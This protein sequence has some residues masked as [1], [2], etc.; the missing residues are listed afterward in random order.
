MLIDLCQQLGLSVMLD[1]ATG[2]LYFD[3]PAFVGEP[4][5]CRLEDMRDVLLDPNARAPDELYW[6][7]RD[8]M[9]P[10]DRETFSEAG[11][12]YGLVVLRP[13]LVGREYIK[14]K[15]HYHTW[16]ADPEWSYPEVYEVVHGCAWFVLQRVRDRQ[17][18]A[19]GHIEWLGCV[20]ANAGELLLVPGNC[21]HVT[22]NVGDVPLVF[23]YLVADASANDYGPFLTAR[24]AACY[25]VEQHSRPT[26]LPNVRYP[27]SPAPQFAQLA[28]MP[29]LQPR[30][31]K[32]LYRSVLR[33]PDR[34]R[35][36]TQPSAFRL[37]A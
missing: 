26:I 8:T 17:A 36:L 6:L 9:F 14:T 23:S 19:A 24:G 2:R 15:G 12:R 35:F 30:L 34:F 18:A 31:S 5:V 29:S 7:Y 13:G 20:E 16:P 37:E 11:L 22:V 27:A 4:G 28:Q 10:A 25:I 1:E 21:G 32:P 3:D 33:S